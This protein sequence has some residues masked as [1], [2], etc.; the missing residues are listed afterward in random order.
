M[1]T[2]HSLFLISFF[3][4]WSLAAVEKL[5]LQHT[6]LPIKVDGLIEEKAWDSA[7][8][9]QL[10]YQTK[11]QSNQLTQIKTEAMLLEDGDNV[12]IAF[13]AYDPDKSA[14]RAFL[15]ERDQG[16]NDDRVIFSVDTFNSAQ[17]AYRFSVNALGVQMDEIRN[18]ANDEELT[19]WDS[20]WASAA[21]ITEFGYVVE[22]AIPLS[23]IRFPA[24]TIQQ[25][26]INLQREYPREQE[27]RL[28]LNPDDRNN[29]CE[30]CQYSLLEGL[31][32]AKPPVNMTLIP[33][34]VYLQSRFKGADGEPVIQ[35]T[36]QQA[37]LDLR[38]G[39]TPNISLSGTL[40]PDFSQVESDAA[41]LDIN[42]KFNIKR[43][44]K[45]HF[46]LEDADYFQTNLDLVHS[47]TIAD[48]DYGMKLTTKTDKNM[49]AILVAQD[50]QTNLVLPGSEG[51]DTER[52]D[53]DGM[54]VANRSAVVR[55]QHNMDNGLSIGG[56]LT[57]RQAQ[58]KAYQN[59]VVSIDSYWQL[60][61]SDRLYVQAMHSTTEYPLD[62]QNEYQQSPKLNDNGYFAQYDHDTETWYHSFQYQNI[63]RD[64]R[65]DSGFI[66]QADF[67][68]Y[69]AKGGYQ[70]YGFEDQWWSK[71][72]W[73]VDWD[74]VFDQAGNLLERTL[75]S[76]VEIEGIG[77]SS[78]EIGM[79]AGDEVFNS[80][81][82]PV[83]S[84]KLEASAR[85][86]SG[87]DISA[88]L[89]RGDK[90]DT[91]NDRVG[92]FV[93]YVLAS[94][95]NLGQHLLLDLTL[96]YETLTIP[97]GKVFSA[98]THDAR[99]RYQFTNN[100]SLALTYIVE[101]VDKNIE[102]YRQPDSEVAYERETSIKLIYSYKLSPQTLFIA[103]FQQGQ[104]EQERLSSTR[105]DQKNTFMKI[106]YAWMN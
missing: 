22:M 93:D 17:L 38:W 53:N 41:T 63:G 56:L 24:N 78:F 1:K 4:C 59:K 18:E 86:Y 8:V 55:Y 48:P 105:T 58:D 21:S 30:I 89:K 83:K 51:S 45:R 10:R 32:G 16:S 87:I 92:Q 70:W 85:P 15:R 3:S 90:V 31:S 5:H 101:A 76:D 74:L 6:D 97:D 37:G 9:L 14:I 104:F 29:S 98:Y 79:E 72:D 13:K 84:Y 46:F 27:Y 67:E 69:H 94:E 12:Y 62:F 44:E 106:S 88:E 28:S 103:G 77:Q 20:T 19:E 23:A 75:E 49:L 7:S 35:H 102:L 73:D 64:F 100:S 50:A 82:Y 47:R 43:D 96:E 34:L 33:S 39:I 95:L 81:S 11:P 36:E 57:H 71:I 68:S 54:D 91:D 80:V 42:E 66:T 99:L 60:N 25:W 2:V 61:D 40:N 65:A 26:R 52:L